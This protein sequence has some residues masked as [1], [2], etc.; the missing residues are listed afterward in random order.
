MH[1]QLELSRCVLD[2]VSLVSGQSP[3]NDALALPV[4]CSLPSEWRTHKNKTY[5][6]LIL[7]DDNEVLCTTNNDDQSLNRAIKRYYMVSMMYTHQE[8]FVQMHV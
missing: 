6:S 3:P 5:N 4:G 1:V 8:G 7:G 2:T